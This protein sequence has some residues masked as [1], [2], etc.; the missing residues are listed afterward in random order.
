MVIEMADLQ[1]TRRG[2]NLL[3][4]IASGSL[5]VVIGAGFSAVSHASEASES[6][7]ASKDA[8]LSS[9]SQQSALLAK[10]PTSKSGSPHFIQVV[11]A[12]GES[13]WSIAAIAAGNRDVSAVLDQIVAAN[14]LRS[15]DLTAGTR[16]LIPTR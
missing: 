3:R 7:G 11:L 15:T 2:R 14:H 6:S 10:S 4:V 8:T 9:S 13:L 16:L 12:P 1:L 5:L